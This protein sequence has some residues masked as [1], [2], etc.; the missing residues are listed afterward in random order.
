[1][2]RTFFVDL[3]N[4]GKRLLNNIETLTRED[5]VVIFH[6]ALLKE[7]LPTVYKEKLL[8]YCGKV[9]IENIT[10]CGKN[11]MDFQICSYIGYYVAREN[12][13]GTRFYILSADKGYEDAIKVIT[14]L[15]TRETN[16][17]AISRIDSFLAL[18]EEQTEKEQ[19]L[20]ILKDYCKKVKTVAC[21]AFITEKTLRNYHIYL[22]KNISRDADIVYRMTKELWLS[23][24]PC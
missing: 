15:I 16:T 12:I 8:K 6:N 22:Q 4:I 11:A 20:N 18:K 14:K 23:C 3:E 9:I 17:A 2:K 5:T 13:A 19:L 1:M 21:T 24:H 7:N 10:C